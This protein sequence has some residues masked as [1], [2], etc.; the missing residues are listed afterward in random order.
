[1]A[2]IGGIQ[3]FGGASAPDKWLLCNGAAIS[4]ADYAELFTVLGT[5]YGVG[6]GT[7]TFNLPDLRGRS[8]YG[9][10][11]ASVPALG[12]TAGAEAVA[13]TINNLPSHDHDYN[14]PGHRH[15][16]RIGTAA[17]TNALAVGTTNNGNFTVTRDNLNDSLTGIVFHAQGGNIPHNNLHPVLG[18]KFIMYAGV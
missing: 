18:V 9:V 8:P 3:A 10:G 5:T 17:G 7:T 13:L 16:Q 4:L 15:T 12:N 6:N 2:A 11:G 1:M 14:D